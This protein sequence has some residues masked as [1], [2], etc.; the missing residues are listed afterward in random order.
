[1]KN[2]IVVLGSC[3]VCHMFSAPELPGRGETLI[4]T[5]YQIVVGGK[6]SG[7]AVVA[8]KLGGDVYILEHLGNDLHGQEEKAS[9]E[10]MGIHAEYVHL[11]QDTPTGSAGIYLNEEGQNAI[12]VVPGANSNMSCS[13][14][15]EMKEVLSGA[16]LLGAQLEIPVKT[17]DYAIRMAAK[18][19]VRTMLD[20]APVAE[21]PEDLFPYISI[22]K[23]N[24]YEASDLT[25]I[26]VTDVE[27]ANRAAHVL[28][29]KGVKE[30]VII[31]LG[32]KGA[33][34]VTREKEEYFPSIPV[35]AVDTGGAGDTF[36]GALLAALARDWSLE[37]SIRYAQCASAICVTR[38]STYSMTR[39]DEVDAMFA[40][41]FP[42]EVND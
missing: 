14:V 20:P 25:G 1:M 21:L 4:G 10:K 15:D 6:G 29:D 7:Q 24:E 8:R 16:K 35:K 26:P 40:E 18:M 36:A 5:D 22:I 2:P 42:D 32:E 9:Y 34:L 33:V 12:I 3:S 37:K 11:D 23:P 39:Q 28:L 30:G 31:T 17:V 13:D 19:G 27:S 38:K 41:H